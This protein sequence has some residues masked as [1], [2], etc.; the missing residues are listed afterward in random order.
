MAI[1]RVLSTDSGGLSEES[2][3]CSLRPK[4]LAECIGQENIKKK[5]NIAITAAKQRKEPLEH[6]LFY[7]PPGLGKTT[8]ANVIANEMNATIRTSSTPLTLSLTRLSTASILTSTSGSFIKYCM[9]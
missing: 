3:N 2:F 1:N 8:L 7:G 4:S 6:I 9:P 5:L